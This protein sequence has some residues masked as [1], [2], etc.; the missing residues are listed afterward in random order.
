MSRQSAER[1]LRRYVKSAIAVA[2][3]CGLKT[4]TISAVLRDV[5][6]AEEAK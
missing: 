6:E 2:R 4:V 1:R 5:I 3:A